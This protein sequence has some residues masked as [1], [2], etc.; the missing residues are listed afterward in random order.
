MTAPLSG[1]PAL[2]A[3]D[4]ELWSTR[5]RLVVTDP[6]ALE[7]ALLLVDDLLA[8]VELAAS[9]FR[10]DAEV[11]RLRPGPDG[12]VLVS[13]LLAELLSAALEDAE[14]TGGAVDPTVGAALSGLGYDR[15]IRLVRS[16]PRLVAVVRPVP[17][18]RVLRLEGRRL[19][20]PERLEID[21]GATAKAVAADRA[22]RL[23]AERFGV[24]AL[25]SLGGDIA[26]SG[27]APAGGW[28]VRVQDAD[29]DPASHVE[30]A[31]GT[32]V[33]TSSTTRRTWWR[34]ADRMHHIVDPGT[35]R[36]ADPVWRTVSVVAAT[37]RDANAAATATIVKGHRGLAWLQGLGLPARLVDR[38]G[39][40]HRCHG[41]PA[42]PDGDAA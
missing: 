33:A 12:T 6:A 3:R 36:P 42:E 37:C 32:A 7:P 35:G 27:R 18:W 5:A 2:A 26:T 40:V 22:A 1:H 34:G 25:V 10:P 29:D 14:R 24:G 41:W 20:L 31:A 17:G 8:E 9:R 30:L 21:L 16:G 38:D 39:G 15:D 19:R 23:V 28:Q 4:W 13:P 11:R